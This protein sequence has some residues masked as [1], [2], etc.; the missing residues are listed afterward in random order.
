M[1]GDIHITGT[2]WVDCTC[3]ED[4]IKLSFHYIELHSLTAHLERKAE[5]EK[6]WGSNGTCPACQAKLD[7]DQAEVEKADNQRRT[8]KAQ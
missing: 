5:L 8:E 3:G 1:T 7:K 6:G 4:S 2:A